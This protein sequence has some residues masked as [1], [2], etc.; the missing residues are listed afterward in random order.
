MSE[1]AKQKLQHIEYLV[2]TSISLDLHYFKRTC[3]HFG[4]GSTSALANS[5]TT[6]E[7][8][9]SPG[10]SQSQSG[11]T[12]CTH[13][14][15]F[16]QLA[17]VPYPGPGGKHCKPGKWCP[18]MSCCCCVRDSKEGVMCAVWSNFHRT[19]INKEVTTEMWERELHCGVTIDKQTC[20]S[21]KGSCS[22]VR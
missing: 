11:V 13:C 12:G 3:C 15:L 21:G 14:S 19:T 17:S 4:C 18:T 22:V 20:F 7:T 9:P 6:L 10:Q 8:F 2:G 16:T 5:P 1:V